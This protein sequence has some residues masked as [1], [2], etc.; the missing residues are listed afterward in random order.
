MRPQVHILLTAIIIWS[1]QESVDTKLGA[2]CVDLKYIWTD[3]TE[4]AVTPDRIV[5]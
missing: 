3:P 1:A 2:H 4:V 5:E